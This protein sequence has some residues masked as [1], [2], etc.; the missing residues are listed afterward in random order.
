ME[1]IY[2]S[3]VMAKNVTA[4]SPDTKIKDVIK[5]L[6]RNRISSLV[7]TENDEPVG[8][9]T[10][11]DLVAIM[12]DMLNDVVCDNLSINCFM[13]SPTFTV[14]SDITLREAIKYS[15]DKR[16]RHLPVVNRNNK[17]IGLLTQTD[18]VIG[19]FQIT[20]I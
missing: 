11:R 4:C 16:I 14:H 17:L 2:V 3:E 10:E 7:I 12:E 9:I 15:I 1:E 5:I 8:I 20:N 19:L 13:S 6:S 18:M